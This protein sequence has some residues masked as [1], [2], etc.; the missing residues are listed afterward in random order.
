MVPGVRRGE[1]LSSASML[2][3]AGT[4]IKAEGTTR[5]GGGGGAIGA[6][7]YVCNKLKLYKVY[8]LVRVDIK[9]SCHSTVQY[10]IHNFIIITRTVVLH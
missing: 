7:K 8:L 3:S 6:Y 2:V 9:V 1:G 10:S 5:E 4:S